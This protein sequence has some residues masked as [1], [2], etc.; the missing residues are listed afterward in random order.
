MTVPSLT[1]V[2]SPN[3]LIVT[4]FSLSTE[5]SYLLSVAFSG[6]TFAFRIVFPPTTRSISLSPSISI[7]VTATALTVIVTESEAPLEEVAVTRVE[8]AAIATICPLASTVATL[9]SLDD[10]IMLSPAGTTSVVATMDSPTTRSVFAIFTFTLLE[11]ATAA[12][13]SASVTVTV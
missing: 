3:A 10:H 11:A 7:P 2:T 12:C 1:A 6:N 9:A 5:Y 4:T 8:P 13:T